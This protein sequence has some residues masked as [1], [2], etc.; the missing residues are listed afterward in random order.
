MHPGTPAQWVEQDR[1]RWSIYTLD[2]NGAVR[3]AGS[4]AVHETAVASMR[5]I[6]LQ[7]I[8][9]WIEDTQNASR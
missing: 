4:T 6:L 1:N 7:G 2:N 3:W 9:A 5:C 8:C